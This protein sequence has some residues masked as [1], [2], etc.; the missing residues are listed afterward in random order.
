MMFF[1]PKSGGF[2]HLIYHKPQQQE[3]LPSGEE[4][5]AS[6]LQHAQEVAC[7]GLTFLSLPF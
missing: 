6:K 1:L 5:V 3:F 7:K 2:G 4:V